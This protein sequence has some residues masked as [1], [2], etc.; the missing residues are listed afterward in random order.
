MN[1]K[2][3][4]YDLSLFEADEVNDKINYKDYKNTNV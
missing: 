1:Q 4:V 2:H 3:P